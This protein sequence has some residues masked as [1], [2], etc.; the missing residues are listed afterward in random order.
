MATVDWRILPWRV[1][2]PVRPAGLR[3]LALLVAFGLALLSGCN[4]EL[5]GGPPP[6]PPTKHPVGHL[7]AFVVAMVV[8]VLLVNAIVDVVLWIAERARHHTHPPGRRLR[9]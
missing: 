1:L 3:T 9:G 4:V 5:F 2:D 7:L 6:W 8:V